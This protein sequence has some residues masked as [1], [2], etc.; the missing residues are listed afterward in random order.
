[1]TP[2]QLQEH[3]TS[4]AADMQGKSGGAEPAPLP[5]PQPRAHI[6]LREKTRGAGL[7]CLG[8]PWIM[9]GLPGTQA[10]SP[11]R[12]HGSAPQGSAGQAQLWRPSLFRRGLAE[13]ESSSSMKY[14]ASLPWNRELLSV[15]RLGKHSEVSQVPTQPAQTGHSPPGSPHAAA[16]AC[17]LGPA[18]PGLRQGLCVLLWHICYLI[19]PLGIGWPQFF[20]VLITFLA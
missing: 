20:Q 18:S 9:P 17:G 2:A 7:C 12:G 16:S 8:T 5:A 13:A 15:G 1:M 4:S 10:T 14:R 3:S 11:G 6:Q 19:A